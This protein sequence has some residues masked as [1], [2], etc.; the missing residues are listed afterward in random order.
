MDRAGRKTDVRGGREQCEYSG[1]RLK[2]VVVSGGRVLPL[3]YC[4]DSCSLHCATERKM[5]PSALP[6]ICC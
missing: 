3:K 4:T 5:L 6:E 2:K 1:K